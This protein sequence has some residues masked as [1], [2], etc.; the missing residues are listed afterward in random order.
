MKKF[1]GQGLFFIF[2]FIVLFFAF[3]IAGSAI[4][5]NRNF[6]NYETE[7]NTLFL[8]KNEHFN[9]MISG[10]SHAR[11]F[12]RHRNHLRVEKIL[13]TKMVNIGQGNGACGINEQYF[14]LQYFYSENNSVDT[15]LFIMSPPMFFSNTLPI[16]SNTFKLETFT[17][18]FFTKY[19]F[20]DTENKGQRLHQYIKSK[21]SKQWLTYSPLDKKIV[22][23]TANLKALHEI[24]HEEVRKGMLVANPKGLDKESFDKACVIVDK[25]IQLAQSKG[26][27][28]LLMVPPALF[29][30]WPGHNQ[31]MEFGTKMEHKYGTKLYDFSETVLDPSCYYDHH[32]LNTKGIVYFTKNYMSTM[33]KKTATN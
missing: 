1:L 15:L 20:F 26:T 6:K 33:F 29:G 22:N 4:V 28:V 16:A 30:K 8:N 12:S 25:A 5:K 31:V 7:S 32:H 2:L 9:L 18:N 14:Y 13:H 17:L 24:N 27:V 23:D 3:F 11:N 21:F 10:I 19:L